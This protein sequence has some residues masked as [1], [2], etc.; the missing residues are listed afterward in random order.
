MNLLLLE[1]GLLPLFIIPA[2]MQYGIW[3]G[4]TTPYWLFGVLFFVLFGNIFF[5][6]QKKNLKIT[7]IVLVVVLTLLM[8]SAIVNRGINAPGQNMG[9][10]DI[11]LQ[12]ESALRFLS[13]GKNPYKE[14]YFGT[15]MESFAYEENGS[16]AVNPALYHFVMPPWYLEFQYPFYFV[17]QRILGYYDA[18]MP[19]L[20]CALGIIWAYYRLFS[21]K[22]LAAIASMVTL[23]GPGLFGYFMEGRSDTFVLFFVLTSLVFLKEK[24]Y[25]ASVLFFTLAFWSKQTVWFF[26]PLYV[27]TALR[28]VKKYVWIPIIVSLMIV[29]PFLFWNSQAFI[30]STILY[31]SGNTA[32]GYPVSGY[33]LSMILYTAGFI[34]NIHDAFP[35]VF[36]QIPVFAGVLLYAVRDLKRS[37]TLSKLLLWHAVTL[38]AVWYASRYFNNSHALYIA[39]LFFLSTLLAIDEEMV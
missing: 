30:G 8:G 9:T 3:P 5:A 32:N 39:L 33:G 37:M 25:A 4:Y 1:A 27:F 35:F 15:P 28:Y 36:I 18:R 22:S 6:L 26:T 23:F 31:L 14:T 21:S 34:K 13:A 19:L 29:G 17:C 24:K 12:A 38:F 10:H 7:P 2:M 20:F 16:P 11:V